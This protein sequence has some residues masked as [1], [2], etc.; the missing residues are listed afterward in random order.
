MFDK[1]SAQK[2]IPKLREPTM[3]R[4][5]KVLVVCI[6]PD[7]LE[8]SGLKCRIDQHYYCQNDQQM[9]RRSAVIRAYRSS[10]IIHAYKSSS[11]CIQYPF[12]GRTTI[13]AIVCRDAVPRSGPLTYKTAETRR[14]RSKITKWL[15]FFFSLCSGWCWKTGD[16]AI[17]KNARTPSRGF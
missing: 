4:A 1:R 7:L 14:D 9:P 17:T 10:P 11:P 2:S 12:A 5:Q 15:G 16:A 8:V 13:D 6:D 3:R